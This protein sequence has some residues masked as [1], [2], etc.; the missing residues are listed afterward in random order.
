MAHTFSLH[1][2]WLLCPS[3][4]RK[5]WRSR[6][7]F[8][9]FWVRLGKAAGANSL[10]SVKADSSIISR[11]LQ[12]RHVGNGLAGPHVMPGTSLRGQVGIAEGWH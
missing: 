6:S 5:S 2:A 10:R 8:S 1:R 4:N 7:N 9:A 11:R 12:E 3:E